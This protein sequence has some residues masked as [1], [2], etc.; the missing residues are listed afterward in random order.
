MNV[1]GVELGRSLNVAVSDGDGE[2]VDSKMIGGIF[3][4]VFEGADAMVLTMAVWIEA[5]L[6]VPNAKLHP[7]IRSKLRMT[8]M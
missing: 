4:G 3:V 1:S 2:A 6:G 8:N 5:S 7:E